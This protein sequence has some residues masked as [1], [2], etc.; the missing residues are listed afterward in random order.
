MLRSLDVLALPIGALIL[1]VVVF[2][3]IAVRALRRPAADYDSI[4]SLPLAPDD[5]L[6]REVV[7]RAGL[8][9][10]SEAVPPRAEPS[11][12]PAPR[13]GAGASSSSSPNSRSLL[14]AGGV[15]P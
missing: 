13:K 11:V 14:P 15:S 5:D 8:E 4:A 7:N 3:V 9:P 6:D 2:V 1:F 10:D 12:R